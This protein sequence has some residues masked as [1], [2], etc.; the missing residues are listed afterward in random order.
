[1]DV[2]Q[3]ATGVSFGIVLDGTGAVWLNS[4]N[5]EVVSTSVPTTGKDMTL[6][7]GPKNL[8]FRK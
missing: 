2:P 4:V 5:F 6:P 3:D 1:L 8:D 7:E